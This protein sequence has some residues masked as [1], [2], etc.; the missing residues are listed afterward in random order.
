MGDLIE[1]YRRFVGCWLLSTRGLP[2]AN[3]LSIS[4]YGILK[5]FEVTAIAFGYPR[6]RS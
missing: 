3:V 2:N 1:N 4:S 6:E 5:Y